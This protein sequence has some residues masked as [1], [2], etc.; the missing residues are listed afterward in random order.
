MR[1]L[2]ETSVR[3]R[4]LVALA[5]IAATPLLA[6]AQPP[7]TVD[8]TRSKPVNLVGLGPNGATL[9]C[10]D[11]SYPAPFAADV[12]CDGKGGV[13]YRFRVRG[14]PPPPPSRAT[15]VAPPAAAVNAPAAERPPSRANVVIPAERPPEG[16]TLLCKDGSFIVADTTSARCA[17]R[18]GVK[19]RFLPRRR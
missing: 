14:T 7:S 17:D 3:A 6:Q 15:F 10:R 16:A 1:L 13:M 11:G 2:L 19:V 18:G 5:A 8:S 4:A 9:R 12:A